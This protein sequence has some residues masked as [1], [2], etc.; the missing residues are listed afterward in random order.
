MVEVV[1]GFYFLLENGVVFRC[2]RG[3]RE[4]ITHL[5]CFVMLARAENFKINNH[6]RTFT[7][8][9]DHIILILLSGQES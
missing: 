4:F 5:Q 8:K 7:Q 2:L 9:T 6:T 1:S 3:A